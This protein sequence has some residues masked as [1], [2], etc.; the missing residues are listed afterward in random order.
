MISYKHTENLY[1]NYNGAEKT[2]YWVKGDHNAKRT[3][4]ITHDLIQFM[5]VRL[6]QNFDHNS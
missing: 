3:K 6:M 1:K 5:K 2:I 4:N